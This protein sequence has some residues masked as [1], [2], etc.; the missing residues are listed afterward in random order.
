[1]KLGGARGDQVAVLSGVRPGDEVVT[2]GVFKLRNGAAVHVNNDVRPG[3]D[4]APTP[5]DN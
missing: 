3:N 2:S 1:V 5:A 4:P